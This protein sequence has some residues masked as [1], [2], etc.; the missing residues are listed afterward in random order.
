MPSVTQLRLLPAPQPLVERL[1][2]EFFR[3]A[4]AAPGVYRM[5]DA[6][7]ELLYV[8]KA[9]DLRARLASYRR[10]HGQSRKTIRLIHAVVRI[11]WEVCA[12]EAGARRREN[13]LIR[14]LRP[15]F[16]RAGTWPRSARFVRVA[17][18]GGGFRIEVVEEP[19]NGAEGV[20]GAFRGGAALAVAALARLLW[21][22]WNRD[23]APASLPR[24]LVARD[25]LREFD[26]EH[27]TAADWL[28][29][30]HAFFA[31]DDDSVLAR[32]VNEVPEPATPFDRLFVARQFEVLLD[33][34]RR[35]PVRNRRLHEWL[36]QDRRTITPEEQSDLLAWLGP[37]IIPPA[38]RLAPTEAD[39]PVVPDP[40]PGFT[41]DRRPDPPAGSTGD[42]I[43]A[44]ASDASPRLPA[45][46]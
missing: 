18:A 27:P 45:A 24:P 36:P 33:F 9:K 8:G 30:I 44:P 35:G 19:G 23:A 22:A 3:T 46:R 5:F 20:Y 14:T 43:P 39:T 40:D 13:E 11:E 15:R 7:G 26:A 28:P 42:T 37:E 38:W 25:E 1:G 34:H 31:G 4:P 16:N 12:D 10:T 17:A 29:A 6:A 21:F 32:L 2:S 41:P